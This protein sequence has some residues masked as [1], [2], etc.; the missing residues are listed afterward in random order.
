MT[1][2]L[3]FDL[4]GTLTDNY[5]GISRCIL[6]A[7]ARLGAPEPPAEALAGCV[8]PPLRH[9]FGRLLGTSEPARIEEAVVLYRE[10]Y[11]ATGWRE[12]APY[13]GITEVLARLGRTHRLLVCTSKPQRY[14]DRI[15]EHFGLR[16]HFAAVYG[17]D[18]AGRLDDKRELLRHATAAEDASAER[19]LMIG[20]RAQDMLAAR[21]NGIVALGVLYGYGSEAELRTAGAD[22][23]CATVAALPATIAGLAGRK[24]DASS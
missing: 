7:C 6:H 9:T 3:F 15:V 22:A 11:E 8:G 24:I 16:P 20:D 12:N 5:D 4:D 17:P 1:E 13:P 19:A 18:L 21:A 10:R 23:L 14:A 2:M